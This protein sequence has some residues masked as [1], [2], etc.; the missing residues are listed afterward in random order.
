MVQIRVKTMRIIYRVTVV[1]ACFI[2]AV[3]CY[4]KGVPAGGAIFFLL[5]LMLE[6]GFW[7]GVFGRKKRSF[8]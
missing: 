4:L 7:A 8:E 2:G 5:G 3:A 1:L 6:L